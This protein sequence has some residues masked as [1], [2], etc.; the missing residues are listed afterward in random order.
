LARL[1]AEDDSTTNDSQQKI[2]EDIIFRD[3]SGN[4]AGLSGAVEPASF[5]F[6][7]EKQQKHFDQTDAFLFSVGFSIRALILA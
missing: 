4:G 5:P 7:F 2:P 6:L 3:L 1:T